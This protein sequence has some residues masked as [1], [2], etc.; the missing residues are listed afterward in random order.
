MRWGREKP[1]GFI[2]DVQSYPVVSDIHAKLR[3]VELTEFQIGNPCYCQEHGREGSA[4]IQAVRTNRRLGS[5]CGSAGAALG[6]G[7]KG[8]D[9]GCFD[10]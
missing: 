2:D 8:L 3:R 5:E 1:K 6:D 4:M 7:L 9:K 10:I